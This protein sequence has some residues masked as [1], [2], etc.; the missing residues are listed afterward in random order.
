MITDFRERFDAAV[1]SESTPIRW[2]GRKTKEFPNGEDAAWWHKQG[3]FMLRRYVATREAL[4]EAGYGVVEGGVEMKALAEIG[5]RPVLG[6][7]DKF[8]MHESGE[9][10][11]V[12]YK[13]GR[14]GSAEPFQFATYAALVR[15]TRGLVVE[16]ALAVFLRAPDAGRRVQPIEFV[17]LVDRIDE[18]YATA[19]AGIDAGMFPVRPSDFCK[20]CAV[21]AHCWYW[22]AVT[23]ED[24][25]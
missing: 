1:A 12:D 24:G 13:T 21:R 9:P 25:S 23:E 16:R 10:V 11:I 14:I 4:S 6:Y 15:R 18:V 7:L 22:N 19:V 17:R 5:G 20:S 8:L 2:G 3:E